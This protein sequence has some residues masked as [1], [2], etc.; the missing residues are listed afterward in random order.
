MARVSNKQVYQ[1]FHQEYIPN[2]GTTHNYTIAF[3]LQWGQKW[4]MGVL[5][6]E[7]YIRTLQILRANLEDCYCPFLDTKKTSLSVVSSRT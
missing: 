4:M 5:Q 2:K 3:T 7:T 1:P 6:T